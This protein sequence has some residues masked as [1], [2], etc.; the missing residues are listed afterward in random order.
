MLHLV[1]FT[2]FTGATCAHRKCYVA[3]SRGWRLSSLQPSLCLPTATLYRPLLQFCFQFVLRRPTG[4]V[5][6][7]LLNLSFSS[8]HFIS[9]SLRSSFYLFFLLFTICVL[10]LLLHSAFLRSKVSILNFISFHI[11]LFLTSLSAFTC[12]VL[13]FSLY[14]QFLLPLSPVFQLSHVIFYLLVLSIPY[15]PIHSLSVLNAFLLYPPQNSAHRTLNFQSY[16]TREMFQ[17]IVAKDLQQ[18]LQGNSGKIW[19]LRNTCREI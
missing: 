14:I 9:I 12:I 8:V 19:K 7:V 3:L 2:I 17:N 10:H 18:T 4:Q 1:C 16:Q 13:S 11:A 15:F 6:L 5:P